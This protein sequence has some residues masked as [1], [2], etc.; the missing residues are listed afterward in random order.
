MLLNFQN[1]PAQVFVLSGFNPDLLF[2]AETTKPDEKL[3]QNP[4]Y[5]LI[6]NDSIDLCCLQDLEKLNPD[7]QTRRFSF[8]LFSKRFMNPTEW[9]VEFYN[10]NATKETTLVDFFKESVMTFYYQGGI[11]L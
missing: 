6:R 10:K 4:I 3:A 5:N 7:E 11:I 8:W 1:I 9:Y 2:G